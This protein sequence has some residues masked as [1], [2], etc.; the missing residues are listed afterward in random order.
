MDIPYVDY[1]EFES[2]VFK[3]EV[4]FS[5]IKNFDAYIPKEGKET[6]SEKVGK[7]KSKTSESEPFADEEDPEIVYKNT[8][9][10]SES[11]DIKEQVDEYIDSKNIDS[12]FK[13]YLKKMA[14]RESSYNPYAKNQFGYMGLYQFGQSALDDVGMSKQ[15]YMSDFR[16]QVD[17][18]IELTRLNY[19]RLE[20]SILLYAG[21]S[22]GDIES[23]TKYGILAGA[24]L[25]GAGR[26]RE[27][28]RK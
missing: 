20:P 11:S 8:L 22:W 28:L 23:L 14:A 21:K 24:H 27:I 1:S 16:N 13:N 9:S 10:P 2:R 25:L 6:I 3:P 17:A 19:K 12:E 7:I 15:Q 26:V 4:S 18:A 5:L